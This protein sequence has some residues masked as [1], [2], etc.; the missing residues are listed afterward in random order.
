MC[1]ED[2][3]VYG[4]AIVKTGERAAMNFTDRIPR[5]EAIRL[6]GAGALAL[7]SRAAPH[8]KRPLS[9]RLSVMIGGY[10]GR[11][12]PLE[13]KLRR[14]ASIHYPAVEGVD[15]K[16]QDLAAIKARIE[17]AHLELAQIGGSISLTGP[18][19]SMVDPK[20]RPR[21]LEYLATA[22]D[23]ARK[24]GTKTLLVLTG[25]AL[26]D[27]S[28]EDQHRSIVDGMKEARKLVEPAGITLIIE[29]LNTYVNHPGYYLNS[30]EKGV[31]VIDDVGSP[32]VKLLNDLYHMQI[33][34]GNLIAN[35]R[36]YID[37]IG[38]F[39]VADVPG[40]HQPGTGEVNYRNVL[41]AIAET[42]YQGYVAMEY[43][44]TIDP[45]ESL[46]QIQQMVADL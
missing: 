4:Y 42:D 23:A 45:L 13:E 21:M 16:N 31:R 41:K 2:C 5:R 26:P 17:A 32:N 39:H 22:I 25:N 15:W 38:H 28:L 36:K 1:C 3:V 35:L 6:A 34:E 12:V 40:R 9:T 7:A 11:N 43:S 20:Q 19:G 46:K 8:G 29:L 10:F 24:L 30:V 27:V 33:M 44:P 18:E 14:L 37:R